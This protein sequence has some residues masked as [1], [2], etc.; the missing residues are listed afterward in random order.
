MEG[1]RNKARFD[2]LRDEMLH[3]LGMDGWANESSGEVESPTGRFSRISITTP[4][5]AEIEDAFKEVFEGAEFDDHR[6]LIGH[7]LVVDSG[8]DVRVSQFD[9]E[10]PLKSAYNLLKKR[11]GEWSSEAKR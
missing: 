3:R 4:E 1:E 10:Q 2:S 6:S 11:Y 5:L 9:S 7:Y 8:G